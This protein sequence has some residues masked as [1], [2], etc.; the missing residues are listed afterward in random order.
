MDCP[1]LPGDLAPEKTQKFGVH[2]TPCM[3]CPAL[4]PGL[5]VQESGGPGTRP[6]WCDHHENGSGGQGSQKTSRGITSL[7]EREVPGLPLQVCSVSR[8]REASSSLLGAHLPQPLYFFSLCR[9]IENKKA[10]QK[11]SWDAV[12]LA[13]LLFIFLS[14]CSGSPE[15]TERF[16]RIETL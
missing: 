11:G 9:I 10:Q 14:C 6:S 2:P 1:P 16:C 15:L 7:S 8:G 12:V 3:G 13:L 5:Q 4:S